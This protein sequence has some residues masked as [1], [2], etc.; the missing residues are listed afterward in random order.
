MLVRYLYVGTKQVNLMLTINTN[1]ASLSVQRSLYSQQQGEAEAM[2][3]LSTGKRINSAKDDAS[4]LYTV[5]KQTADIRAKAQIERGLMDGQSMAQTVEGSLAEIQ[6]LIHRMSELAIQSSNETVEDR[7]GLQAEFEQL[8]TQAEKIIDT[9][10]IFGTNLLKSKRVGG[11]A[12]P[13]GTETPTGS[14]PT[15]GPGTDLFPASGY[16]TFGVAEGST[17][18]VLYQR[19]DGIREANLVLFD[20]SG[21]LIIGPP[22]SNISWANAGIDANN[23]DTALITKENGFYI[24]AQYDGSKVITPALST[25]YQLIQTSIGEVNYRSQSGAFPPRTDI[26]VDDVKKDFIAIYI[27]TPGNYMDTNYSVTAGETK[28][29]ILADDRQTSASYIDID[30]ADVNLYSMGVTSAD[31]S[32][33]AGAQAAIDPLSAAIDTISGYRADFGAKSSRFE[34]AVSTTESARFNVES[35]RSRIEDTDFAAETSK[36][37]RS[38]ILKQAATSMLAQAN[39]RPNLA[40][41]LLNAA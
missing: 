1:T 12:I 27:G 10:E 41:T 31:I 7:T 18:L 16:V 24:D 23:I 22:L 38:Q 4:G 26:E 36:L 8:Q 21:K 28:T 14:I 40:L 20:R 29:K 33:L 30:K 32:T 2:Q 9:S 35:S 6:K 15:S 39:Q 37:T 3:R 17:D 5:D 19:P 25:S 34:A 11:L 13:D